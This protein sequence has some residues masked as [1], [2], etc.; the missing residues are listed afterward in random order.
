MYVAGQTYSTN[1]ALMNA[2]QLTNNADAHGGY[3][4]FV[5]KF[6]PTATGS[7]SLLYSTYL[8]GSTQDYVDAIAVDS[9][10]NAYVTGFTES[11]DFPSTLSALQTTFVGGP[12]RAF[13]TEFDPAASGTASLLYSTYLG[14]SA[15]GTI[16]EGHAIA[17]DSKG[18]AYVTGGTTS[19]DF[20][21][22][23]AF[24]STFDVTE[25]VFVTKLDPTAS[26]SAGLLYS[27][28][29]GGNGTDRG[30]GIAVDSAGLAYV[31]G[32]T[33]SLNFPIK[34]SYQSMDHSVINAFVAKFDPSAS[35]AASLL[36]STYLGGSGADGDM[37]NAIAVDSDGNADITGSTSSADFPTLNPFQKKFGG[38]SSN[39][40][41]TQF[42]Q[43]SQPTA[44]ATATATA[45]STPSKTPTATPSNGV[46]P[47]PT[48]T[49]TPTATA[50]IGT[51]TATPTPTPVPVTLKIKPKVLKFPKTTVGTTSKPKKVKV[52]N[53]K[54]SKKHMGH[55]VLIEM[56]SDPDVFKQTNNCP[57]SL[58]AGSSCTISVTFTPSAATKQT[59]TL[60]ITDNANGSMQKVPLSGPGK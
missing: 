58:A 53:P 56:I 34:N 29:L 3:T 27:T 4:G 12:I 18:K 38:G 6:D 43:G 54:S 40:F 45:T 8:G 47:T 51:P 32:W 60:T 48:S 7:A 41:V 16:D 50:T 46:T 20:P 17:V 44:S 10:G 1:L 23:N 30:L 28:Y 13:M 55:P 22:K 26:G 25:S 35:G 14:G 21:I 33:S 2:F 9:V 42:S 24:Q 11:N 15:A 37:G 31:T 57:A 52:S 49:P 19:T 36:Y 39:A 5:A 59:G